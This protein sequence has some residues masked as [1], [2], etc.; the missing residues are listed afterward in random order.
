[1]K[2][3]EGTRW[4]AVVMSISGTSAPAAKRRVGFIERMTEKGRSATFDGTT[5]G[6]E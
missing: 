1:M 4:S 2:A 3:G 5:L 6:Q